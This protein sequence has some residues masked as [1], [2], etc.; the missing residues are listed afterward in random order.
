M[1]HETALGTVQSMLFSEKDTKAHN[2]RRLAEYEDDFSVDPQNDTAAQIDRMKRKIDA[3]VIRIEALEYTAK[4]LDAN[5]QY[6]DIYEAAASLFGSGEVV[7]LTDEYHRGITELVMRLIGIHDDDRE[8]VAKTISDHIKD[9]RTNR[10]KIDAVIFRK[11]PDRLRTFYTTDE[12]MA[13]VG[14]KNGDMWRV[15][16]SGDNQ[17]YKR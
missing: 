13:V 17:H 4:V 5:Q 12:T 10:Q 2:V 1:D 16:P 3:N 7:N 8:D 9:T 15:W 14:D 6:D 11:F